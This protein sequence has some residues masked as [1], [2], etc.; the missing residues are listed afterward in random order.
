MN[1]N[2]DWSLC[3][4]LVQFYDVPEAGAAPP[5]I[6]LASVLIAMKHGPPE[7]WLRY[8]YA[9]VLKQLQRCLY[10]HQIP[11]AHKEASNNEVGENAQT[12][13]CT[14]SDSSY[15]IVHHG[16]TYGFWSWLVI[17]QFLVTF[18]Y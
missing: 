11:C 12:E 9:H 2:V 7:V 18:A 1:Q 14:F 15:E 13:V 3:K 10:K 8:G 17:R 6:Q 5:A 16:K 4:N